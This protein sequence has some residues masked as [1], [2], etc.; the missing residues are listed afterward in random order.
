MDLQSK[1][2]CC[3]TPELRR[4][5][6]AATGSV[7]PAQLKPTNDERR[8]VETSTSS[9]HARTESDLMANRHGSAYACIFSSMTRLR[10]FAS[11]LL[12][13]LVVQFALAATAVDCVYAQSSTTASKPGG[14]AMA[15]MDMSSARAAAGGERPAPSKTP[16][17]RPFGSSSC[18]PFA[19]C[20][21]GVIAPSQ[22]AASGARAPRKQVASLD[23]STPPSRSTPPELPPPRA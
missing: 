16:C 12:L 18:Q 19:A 15:G 23:V 2:A 3:Q 20:S 21:S 4:P 14:A 17:N 7:V 22:P 13:P 1:Q 8:G 9:S 11:L 10:R 5:C 6:R